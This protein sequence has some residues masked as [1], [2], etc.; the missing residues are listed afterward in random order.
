MAV[1]LWVSE[2]GD[3]IW[4][5]AEITGSVLNEVDPLKND[6][7]NDNMRAPSATIRRRLAV[8]MPGED[9]PSRGRVA[10]RGKLQRTELD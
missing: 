9:R 8:A 3:L 5:V 6:Y 1:V 4:A 2:F 7:G 10:Y